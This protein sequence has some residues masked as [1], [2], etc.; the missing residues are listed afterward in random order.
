MKYISADK[1][2]R[3]HLQL[4]QQFSEL[5]GRA[6]I[7]F[8]APPP[9]RLANSEAEMQPQIKTVGTAAACRRRRQQNDS[10]RDACIPFQSN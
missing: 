3:Q 10:H 1:C 4:H 5:A 8:L 7:L 6:S 2:L 9:I